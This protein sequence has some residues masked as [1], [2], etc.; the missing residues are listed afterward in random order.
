MTRVS[1]VATLALALFA[2]PLVTEAETSCTE[3]SPHRRCVLEQHFRRDMANA[4]FVKAFLEGMEELHW[5]KDR[6]FVLDMRP[7]E[8]VAGMQMS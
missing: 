5:V 7:M 8:H 4:A 3:T 1:M 2:A 6:D